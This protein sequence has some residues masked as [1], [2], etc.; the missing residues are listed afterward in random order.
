MKNVQLHIADAHLA[1]TCTGLA[2][3]TFHTWTIWRRVTSRCLDQRAS[4]FTPLF[5]GRLPG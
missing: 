3:A 5:M 4:R 2:A 1:T